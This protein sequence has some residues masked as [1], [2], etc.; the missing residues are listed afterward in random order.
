MVRNPLR[1]VAL[2]VLL[3]AVAMAS[4]VIGTGTWSSWPVVNNDGTPFWD[5]SSAD[6]GSCNVGYFLAGGFNTGQNPCSNLKNGTPS[7][8]LNLGGSNLEYFSNNDNITGFLLAAG[9]WTFTLE[10]RIAGSETFTVG[11]FYPQLPGFYSL[12]TQANSVGDSVTINVAAPIALYLNDQSYWLYS[13]QDPLGAA[14][15]HYTP[16]QHVYYFGFEDRLRGDRDY[17]DVVISGQYVPEP[18]TYLLIG[19]GLLAIGIVRRRL[20]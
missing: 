18:G 7:G 11:Y 3:A 8:G 4:P 19:A 20:A 10:G 12:F 9:E 6:G 5:N 16:G 17:N 15:F 1:L 14:A 13:N 2:A